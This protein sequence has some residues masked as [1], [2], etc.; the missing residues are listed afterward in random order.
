GDAIATPC[1]VHSTPMERADEQSRQL[2]MLI[3]DRLL[4]RSTQGTGVTSW[5]DPTAVLP[6]KG[7]TVTAGPCD[8]L[9]WCL[10]PHR[11]A[12][13]PGPASTIQSATKS[14]LVLSSIGALGDR[15][16]EQAA[17]KRRRWSSCAT[18]R[19][20]TGPVEPGAVSALSSTPTF[21]PIPSLALS[22]PLQACAA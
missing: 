21:S 20:A 6:A 18:S 17:N 2:T 19:V 3:D 5:C 11:G 4:D 10:I 13:T 22:A 8:V 1:E 7:A 15:A 9:T 16:Y 12:A 14:P